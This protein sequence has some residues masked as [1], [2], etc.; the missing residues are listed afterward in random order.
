MPGYNVPSYT[1]S[2]ISIGPGVLFLAAAGN[3]PTVD[4]GAVRSAELTITREK[5][6]VDQGFPAQSIV[7]Y[8]IG[9]DVTLTVNAIEWDFTHLAQAL[10]A[11][12]VGANQFDFGG[13]PNFSEVALK[14]QH[15]M[16]AGSTI[17]IDIWRA[18]GSGE[19]TTTFGDDVQEFPYSFTALNATQS[20]DTV[21]LGDTA[22]MFQIRRT[23]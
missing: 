5:L 8:A 3:T 22:S 16:A 11:G 2:N 4:V 15:R 19:I 17:V 21:A 6:D 23:D 20:W 14:F 9:E 12:N 1:T 10:G 18:N 13:D 7:S